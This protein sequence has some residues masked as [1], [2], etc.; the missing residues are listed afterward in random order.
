VSAFVELPPQATKPTDSAAPLS[1]AIANFR[2]LV[3]GTI[4]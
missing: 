4:K 1:R 3:E 2:M